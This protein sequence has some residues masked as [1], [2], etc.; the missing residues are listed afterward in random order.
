VDANAPL[1]IL[2]LSIGIVGHRPVRIVDPVRVRSRI[3]EVLDAADAEMTRLAAGG[4]WSGRQPLVLVSALAEGADRLAAAAALDA[5]M[6]LGAVLPFPPD[7]YARDFATAEAREEFRSLLAR[8]STRLTLAGASDARERAYDAAGMALLDNCDLLLAV[9][10]GEGGRGRGGTRE[11]IEEAARRAMPVI[12]IAPDGGTVTIRAAG[13]GDAMRF[14]DLPERPLERLAETIE[15]LVSLDGGPDA[16]EWRALG[17]R[18]PTSF[19]HGAYP[20]M[21]RL[22]GALP[23][24]GRKPAAPGPQDAP[25]GALAA[26]FAWWDGSAIRAAQAF[27]SAVIVNFALAAL[28]VVLAATSIL[29]GHA[30]WLFVIAEIATILL[31][32]ANAWRARRRRWQQRW[33]GSREVAELLRV[34]MLLRQVGIGRGWPGSVGGGHVGRYAAA[35]ARVQEP[36]FL[37]LADGVA[38]DALVAEVAGQAAWNEA[39]SRRLHLAAHRIQ[40]FGEVLFVIVLAAAVLWLGVF[41]ASPDGAYALS[42]PLV[43]ITAGLPAIATASYGIRIIL[44]LEGISSRTQRIAERL[45]ALLA[46]WE[47]GPRTASALQGFARRASD[48]MLADVAAWRLLAEGRRLTIP[49]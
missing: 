48:I 47:T 10:D 5:G 23:W 6:A 41:A 13:A 29:A 28:A 33:L 7:E 22:V 11:V 44:D 19:F 39:T 45:Q 35:L 25:R 1:P 15:A 12:V 3:V 4:R 32:L 17:T 42:A 16:E 37:D 38:A 2:G 27:R 9:W 49:G 36:L 26:A 8:A 20:L 40:R 21:L 24:R 46:R 31:L 18:L 34:S 43:A 14:E 30:K